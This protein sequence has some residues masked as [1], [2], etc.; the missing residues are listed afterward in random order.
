MVMGEARS[1]NSK[2]RLD[3]KPG[4]FAGRYNVAILP[5]SELEISNQHAGIS[6]SLLKSSRSRV[7]GSIYPTTL[8]LLNPVDLAIQ[9]Q[10]VL[11]P[12]TGLF[13]N[14]AGNIFS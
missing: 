8:N 14:S 3:M 10:N 9:F 2:P 11:E 5:A 13:I 4:S 7:L 6:A 1:F 12:K